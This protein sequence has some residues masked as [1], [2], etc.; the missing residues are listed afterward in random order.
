MEDKI[1]SLIEQIEKIQEALIELQNEKVNEEVQRKTYTNYVTICGDCS[2]DD[3]KTNDDR[4]FLGYYAT[5]NYFK[6]ST[7]SEK[8]IKYLKIRM[9]LIELAYRLNKE[10]LDWHNL[11]QE[12]YYLEY[13]MYTGAITQDC[14]ATFRQ[15][16][17]IYCLSED[18]KEEAAHEI[19]R[20]DL[21]FFLG[22][23]WNELYF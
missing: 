22:F 23:D 7:D 3:N 5:G 1:N 19:G 9:R 11:N 6:N 10:E 14:I 4:T 15:P 8:V 16:G 20:E 17:V 21:V 13:D 12:K 18:W 2:I